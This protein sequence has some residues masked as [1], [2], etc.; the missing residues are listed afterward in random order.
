MEVKLNTESVIEHVNVY[1]NTRTPTPQKRI[2][3]EVT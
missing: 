3:T 1:Q 2:T